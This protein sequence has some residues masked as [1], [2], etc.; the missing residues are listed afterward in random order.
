[1]PSKENQ[2]IQPKTSSKNATIRTTPLTHKKNQISY[3]A[4]WQQKWLGKNCCLTQLCKH[5][6]GSGAYIFHRTAIPT[7]DDWQECYLKE[8]SLDPQTESN[9]LPCLSKKKAPWQELLSY[10]AAQALCWIECLMSSKI[11]NKFNQ[12]WLVRMLPQGPCPQT[13]KGIKSASLPLN[14]KCTLARTTVLLHCTSIVLDWVLV[15]FQKNQRERDVCQLRQPKR[16]STANQA[17]ERDV[18]NQANKKELSADW[19]KEK[20]R[21]TDQANKKEVCQ[22]SQRETEVCQ[23]SQQK[24]EACWSSQRETEVS[25]SSQ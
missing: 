6:V 3:L 12:R 11:T 10:S 8:N 15:V 22:S 14:N 16:E 18:A 25:K 23:L 5:H 7:K 21:S 13:T 1:M 19:A 24:R 9:Q 20:E 4:L 17:K 2:Q